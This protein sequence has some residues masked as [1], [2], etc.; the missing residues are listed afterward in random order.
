MLTTHDIG[1]AAQ[2]DRILLLGPDGIVSD[3]A[4]PE[5]L[6][7][8]TAWQGLGLRIPSWVKREH[9]NKVDR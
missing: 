4:A 2:A 1:L 6:A 7:D 9:A 5:V 8:E 3:G